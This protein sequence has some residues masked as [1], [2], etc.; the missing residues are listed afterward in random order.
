MAKYTLAGI[1]ASNTVNAS[2]RCLIKL[3]MSDDTNFSTEYK[4][5]PYVIMVKNGE[6]SNITSNITSI[7][8][9]TVSGTTRKQITYT[10]YRNITQILPEITNFPIADCY[11]I[12]YSAFDNS[13]NVAA[14]ITSAG[15]VNTDPVPFEIIKKYAPWPI[16]EAVS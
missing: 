15:S 3:T 6:V 5:L 9:A 13:N 8:D 4:Y 14:E 1:T 7:A 11:I 16:V 2:N 10:L 12:A